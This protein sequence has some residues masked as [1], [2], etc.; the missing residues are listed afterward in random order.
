MDVGK[1]QTINSYFAGGRLF[2]SRF[3]WDLNYY[4]WISRRRL[5]AW[6]NRY[7]G[8]RAII[9]GNGPSL[10]KV[11][12][13]ALSKKNIFTFGLNKIYLMFSKIDFRPSVIACADNIQ[14]EQNAH[15]Y[16]ETSL[17]L[18]IDSY[19]TKFIKF[20]K[21]VHFLHTGNSTLGKFARDC[22]MSICQGYSTTYVCM[23]LAFHM[24]FS[25]VALVGCD[26]SFITP[27]GF[28][29]QTLIAGQ[30]DL[31]HFDPAYFEEG[32]K[33]NWPNL[34]LYEF[35][36]HIAKFVYEQAGRRIVNCT[37]GGKLEVFERQSLKEFMKY[38][39]NHNL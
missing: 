2:L 23:Q 35:H 39:S 7:S 38:G 19:G 30:K 4:S 17:P 33:W 15:F 22:S 5:K 6:K 25:H 28:A 14:I 32:M 34:E 9:L 12:F 8:Q 3:T 10:N 24:G 11:D 31:N 26:H 27:K 21:N 18:F 20:R 16:N 1:R 37:D 13:E 29:N 36:Y